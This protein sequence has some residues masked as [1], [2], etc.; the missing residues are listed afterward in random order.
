MIPGMQ[1]DFAIVGVGAN[2]CSDNY[3]LDVS[4]GA[5]EHRSA[6]FDMDFG[7]FITGTGLSMK[8][9]LLPANAAMP[10]Y[11]PLSQT[12]SPQDL[13]LDRT[14]TGSDSAVFTNLTTPSMYDGSPDALASYQASPMLAHD[15]HAGADSSWYSLFPDTTDHMAS[16]VTQT[17]ELELPRQPTPSPEPASPASPGPVPDILRSRLSS[18]AG[19]AKCRRAVKELSPIVVDSGDVKAF[20]RAKN[21]MA[22]RKS[23]QKKRDVEE[24]LRYEL[25]AMTA[26]RDRWMH[27][28]IQH[29]APLPDV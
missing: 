10:E 14:M 7:D 1:F 26:E 22:A 6:S 8:D 9:S 2:P 23:R 13:F 19:V 15:L 11:T 16:S 18:V 17:T 27:I 20:K 24:Q 21:T 28:A 29:G 12:V 5:A 3:C 25:A 4:A